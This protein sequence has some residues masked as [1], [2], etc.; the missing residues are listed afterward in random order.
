MTEPIILDN[1]KR[2][3]FRQCKMK[4]FLS[5]VNG[6]QSNFG[7]TAIR[8]GVTWHGI[9]EG[10]HSWIKQNSWPTDSTSTMQALTAGLELGKAKYDKETESKTYYDDYK[11]FNTAVE[12][13]S[14]Y[15]EFF[16]TDSEFIKIIST[17]RKF[18]C[19]IEPEN[20]AE[21]KLLS[22]LPP[23]VFTGRIDLCVEMDYAKW[24]FDFKTTGWI[25]DQVIAKSNRSPQ[26]I[27]YS[28]AGEKV[29]DFKPAGCLCSFAYVGSNKSKVTGEWGNIRYDFRRVPQLYTQGDIDAWKLSFIDTCREIEWCMKNGIWTE[30]FD[31]CYQYGICPY[32]KLCQQHTRFEELNLEG[33]HV[34]FWDVMEDEV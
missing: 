24:I 11:N 30:S 18:S 27:G 28:Q 2:S 32:L 10:F 14:K 21:D 20:E 9:Q 7:S 25:L 4:Y 3:T 33:Y 1:T 19:P 5:A 12:G 23:I 13:F 29:L 26:L 8:Y 16:K 6:L 17:E 31:N 22:K 34:A 15:L